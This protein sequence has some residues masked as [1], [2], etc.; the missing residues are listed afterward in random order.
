MYKQSGGFLPAQQPDAKPGQR[1]AVGDAGQRFRIGEGIDLPR[2][3]LE[4]NGHGFLENVGAVGK[5]HVLRERA[6]DAQ[7]Q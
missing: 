6:A 4:K 3:R 5:G 1:H 7:H 2:R